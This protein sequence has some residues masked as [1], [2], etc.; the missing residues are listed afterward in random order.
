MMIFLNEN[1]DFLRY[2]EK[3]DAKN[4]KKHSFF[5]KA[6]AKVDSL[7]SPCFD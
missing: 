6:L 2:S 5:K 3:M 4:T 7:K 1:N